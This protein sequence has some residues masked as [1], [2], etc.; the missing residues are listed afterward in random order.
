MNLLREG[1]RL[2][3][4]ATLVGWTACSGDAV[5]ARLP[6]LPIGTALD[7]ARASD[8][9]VM[10]EFGATWCGPCKRLEQ[11]TLVDPKGTGLARSQD[12]C[13]SCRHRR[14]SRSGGRV[15]GAQ[16]SDH[17]VRAA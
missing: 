3:M 1:M 5:E 14:R 16:R 2:A 6:R 15:R 17:G 10:L 8:K 9:V 12:G 7:Q 13:R 11:S 4:C